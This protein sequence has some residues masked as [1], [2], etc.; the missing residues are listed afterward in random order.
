MIWPTCSCPPNFLYPSYLCPRFITVDGEKMSKTIG[1]VVDP[2]TLVEKYGS[3]VVR[4]FLL[5]EIP[6]GADGDSH[7]KNSRNATMEPAN[8]LGNWFKEW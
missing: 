6:S 4:Y 7:T 3:E 5:R 1:N 2:F 8:G